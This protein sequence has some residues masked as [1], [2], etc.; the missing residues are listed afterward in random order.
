MGSRCRGSKILNALHLEHLSQNRPEN[1]HLVLG[2]FPRLRELLVS[3]SPVS[4]LHM[5][6]D[7]NSSS[8]VAGPSYAVPSVTSCP[9]L[10]HDLLTLAPLDC[11]ARG[12]PEAVCAACITDLP[13]YGKTSGQNLSR[14]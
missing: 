12:P 9:P 2:P 4:A 5:Y 8:S 13:G 6:P 14:D 10:S 7:P 3:E 1:K 11:M